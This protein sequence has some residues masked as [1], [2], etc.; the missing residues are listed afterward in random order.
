MNTILIFSIIF[1]IGSAYLALKLIPLTGKRSAWILI[2]SAILFMVFRRCM[3]LYQT[4]QFNLPVNDF[5]IVAELIA[6]ITSIFMFL[7]IAQIK[8][9]FNSIKQTKDNLE[10]SEEKYR[11]LFE[12]SKDAIYETNL[13]GDIIGINQ[14]FAELFGYTKIELMNIN[15][16]DIYPVPEDRFDF[17]FHIEK[18]GYLKDYEIKFRKK[19]GTIIDCIMTSGV[20]MHNKKTTGYRGIIRDISRRKQMEKALRESE[21]QFRS[22]AESTASGIFII[23][24]HRF[25]Y[26]NPSGENISGYSK[27][28]LVKKT[29]RNIIHQDFH[30]VIKKL[31]DKIVSNEKFCIR[32]EIKIITQ[33]GTEKWIDMTITPIKFEEHTGI[34]VT[35]FDITRAKQVEQELRESEKRYRLF[36][37]EDL[38]GDYLTDIDGR[39]LACNPAFAK[40]FGFSSVKEAVKHD[41]SQFYSSFEKRKEFLELLQKEKKLEYYEIELRDK[42]NKQIHVIENAIGIFNEKNELVNMKGYIFDITESKKIEKQLRQSQ[43]ME[44][45]GTLAGGIAHD[46]N[47]ILVPIIGYAEMALLQHVTSEKREKYIKEILKAATRAKELVHQIVTFSRQNECKKMPLKIQFIIKEA[48]KL[49]ISSLPATIKIIQNIDDNCGP[50]NAEPVQIHQIIMNLCT[51]AYHA[52]EKTGGKLE[53]GLSE[54]YMDNNRLNME[55]GIKEGTYLRLTVSDTGCGMDE[56]TMSRIFEP[57]FTTKEKGKGT[58]LGLAIIHGIVK[59]YN[60]D[61]RV[62][63]EVQKGTTFQIYLPRIFSKEADKQIENN[64]LQT[65]SERILLID[66]ELPIIEMGKEMLENLGYKVTAFK[67]GIEA[68]EIFEHNPENFD[69]VITD[70]T[71]SCI[72]GIELAEKLLKIRADIPIILCSGFSEMVT[73]AN[74]ENLGICSYLM[75]PVSTQDMSTAIRKAIEKKI[76]PVS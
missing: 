52:M 38:T 51:N 44:A 45:I 57:Y 49:I 67:N 68:A 34:L 7:G 18:N 43:K 71:M 25:K 15:I 74:I 59:S 58:G 1:Q 31:I 50:V 61:I 60:G 16:K 4:I 39:I 33:N 30:A 5:E 28:N 11:S 46:F 21:S 17:Q 26:V 66:D 22:L 29:Y 8:S 32:D 41:A 73:S 13:E 65:G 3:S 75:K 35:A 70:Q 62:Y 63:S 36:F 37:E 27:N 42:N 55:S 9:L 64:F 19:D 23:Q 48:L 24:G 14:S 6:L 53:I 47:N 69:I 56:K 76:K 72:T 40:I 10:Q 54:I 2:S 20:R 12:E